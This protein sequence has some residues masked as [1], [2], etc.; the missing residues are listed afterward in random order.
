MDSN[1]DD[2]I[3]FMPTNIKPE[4]ILES[5]EKFFIRD[6]SKLT[7]IL[8]INQLDMDQFINTVMP[9]D[10]VIVYPRY[11]N[12][13]LFRKIS[14]NLNSSIQGSAYSSMKMIIDS[15][16]IVGFGTGHNSSALNKVPLTDYISRAGSMIILRHKK[17]TPA[18][19]KKLI[20]FVERKL[21]KNVQYDSA[22]VLAS[23]LDH[24]FSIEPDKPLS[25][26]ELEQYS[27][28]L[29][30]STIFQLG[31]RYVGLDSGISSI[32]DFRVWPRDFLWSPMFDKVGV[33][34]AKGELTKE[35]EETARMLQENTSQESL[36]FKFEKDEQYLDLSNQ[37]TFLHMQGIIADLIEIIPN[38]GKSYT[39]T[40]WAGRVLQ[41]YIDRTV[42]HIKLVQKCG[43]NL[44]PHIQPV[45]DPDEF[46]QALNDHDYDKLHHK[47]IIPVYA[48]YTELTYNKKYADLLKLADGVEEQFLEK[49]WPLHYALN[50]HHVPEHYGRKSDKGEYKYIVEDDN[51]FL[52][53]AHMVADWMAMGIELG[54]SANDWWNKKFVEGKECYFKIEDSTWIEKLLK[55]EESITTEALKTIPDPLDPSDR[56]VLHI[57]I[58]KP[59]TLL[60]DGV[61]S[62]SLVPEEKL[63]HYSGRAGSTKKKDIIKYLEDTFPGRSRSVCVLT[64]EIPDSTSA[65]L[66]NFKRVTDHVVL[67]PIGIL[68]KLGLIE[69]IYEN[70]AGT[71]GWKKVEDVSYDPPIDWD[72]KSN[73]RIFKGVRHYAIVLKHGRIPREYVQIKQHSPTSKI[74]K[75]D[76]KLIT[77]LIAL[78]K[79]KY[80]PDGQNQWPHI[81]RVVN[82]GKMICEKLNIVMTPMMY[83]ATLFHDLDKHGAGKKSHGVH[84]AEITKK[85]LVPFFDKLDIERICFAIA[86]HSYD[87]TPASDLS[88]FLKS[89]DANY[90]DIPWFLNKLYWKRINNNDKLQLTEQQIY[91]ECLDIIQQGYLTLDVPPD[92]IK[93]KYWLA[94]YGD[95]L[96]EVRRQVK[97]LTLESVEQIIKDYIKKHGTKKAFEEIEI[98]SESLE[99]STEGLAEKKKAILDYI[100]K[101][102]DLMD[103]SKLNSNR[104]RKIIGGMS[105]KQFDEFM[106][107]MRDDKFQLHIVAPNMKLH[108]KNSDL[109][110]A[111]DFINLKL[112]HRIW[113]TDYVT[114]RRY[115]TPEEYLV[116]QLPIRRQQQFLDEKM[117]VPDND[118]TIDGLTGQVTGD[119]RACSITNPEI[120]ILAA[121]NLNYTLQEFVTVRG[122]NIAQYGEMK[123]QLE[124]TGEVRLNRLDPNSKTRVAVVANVLLKSMMIDNNI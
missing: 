63:Q 47:D 95:K 27:N 89:A 26:E 66:L 18:K 13:S 53:I 102:C 87:V 123:R 108:L 118:K 7:E 101:A 32:S 36:G 68:K 112:F 41:S 6:K 14:Y 8:K 55:V 17:M 65:E 104:Y 58:S 117:S 23:I 98:S 100:C 33:Y 80:K 12:L 10:F 57:Y 69:A 73:A 115:L 1:I 75:A 39:R 43:R 11:H 122:G 81:T 79:T 83:A 105:D 114:G 24:I 56:Q 124:E 88:D 96:P 91:A 119:S 3:E 22:A 120:Q 107:A 19:A 40:E 21:E 84:A 35:F 109:L 67:P 76:E 37:D 94:L 60:K 50:D 82:H 52:P 113:M 48:A 51:H 64:E 61:L 77:D 72:R 29:F 106:K 30:C 74:C 62:P 38:R 28:P 70:S 86:E 4:D 46:I 44:I 42:K 5:S 16:T 90:L 99:V 71:K 49:A 9:G 54:N 116:V 93:P 97:T 2:L 78:A 92:R 45:V 110:K 34:F 111:A 31:L 85:L 59:N 15:K 25:K 20:M 121:R 103:P